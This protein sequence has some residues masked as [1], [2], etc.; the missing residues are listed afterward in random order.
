[1]LYL[2]PTARFR[3][4]EHSSLKELSWGDFLC[5]FHRNERRYFE[6]H[7]KGLQALTARAVVCFGMLLR[8]AA[9]PIV[10][11]R[12]AGC[13]RDAIFIYLRIAAEMLRSKLD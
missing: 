2:L 4:F 12:R 9:I 8:I 5:L 11:D 6:K 3:H 7:H 13:R 1:V 10:W